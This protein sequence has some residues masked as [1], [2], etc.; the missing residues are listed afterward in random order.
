MDFYVVL[1]EWKKWRVFLDEWDAKNCLW[2]LS[3]DGWVHK[4]MIKYYKWDM[5]WTIIGSKQWWK[6]KYTYIAE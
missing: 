2:N 1:Y 6:N 4:W 3:I 5:M